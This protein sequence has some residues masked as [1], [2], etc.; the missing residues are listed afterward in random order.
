MKNKISLLFSAL[1]VSA[2]LYA[3]KDSN[4]SNDSNLIISSGSSASK[5]RSDKEILMQ[6]G[7]WFCECAPD[8]QVA[9]SSQK[10][11]HGPQMP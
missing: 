6:S 4:V 2:S 5:V 9:S 1:A 10:S 11:P 3:M 8:E 7:I